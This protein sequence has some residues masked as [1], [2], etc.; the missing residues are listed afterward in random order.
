[1]SDQFENTAQSVLSPS[2]HAFAVSPSD[3]DPLAFVPKY[4][5]VGI[6]GS[7]TLRTRDSDTDVVFENVPAGGYLYVRAS[8]V[9]ATGTTASAIVACA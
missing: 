7:V 8:H 9:R 1:M 4:L 2:E 3:T 6:A 5:F